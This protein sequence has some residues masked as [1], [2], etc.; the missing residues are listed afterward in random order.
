[1]VTGGTPAGS[2]RPV[3]G[4]ATERARARLEAASRA[5]WL[6]G[7]VAQRMA[8]RLS[9]LRQPPQSVIDWW[10]LAGGSAAAL[11]QSLPR[12]RIVRRGVSADAARAAWWAPWRARPAQSGEM[13][14]VAVDL[15][16]ANMLLHHVADPVPLIGQWH[17]ALRVGGLLMFS[18]L[19][20]GTLVGLCDRYRQERWG[21]PMADL[22]DMHDIGDMLVQAGFADPVMDQEV[23]QL[24]WAS[25]QDALQELRTLG[26]NAAPSRFAGLRTPAWK[27][28]LLDL[29][30]GCAATAAGGR[31]QLEFELVY[32]HAVK[33]EPRL[34]VAP[35]ARIDAEELRRRL[36]MRQA[37]SGG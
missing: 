1:M 25:A 3:D 35:E 17:R 29:L 12:A 31:V 18:T 33:P 14:E 30:S 27:R 26:S 10:P 32:G 16:W 36:R 19:G 9:L 6:H 34:R 21:P 15:V 22:V 13:S 37:G 8:Q 23:L 7:Q 11:A 20:P 2:T 4:V 28:R 24:S 5:A